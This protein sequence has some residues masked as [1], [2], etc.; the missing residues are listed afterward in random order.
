LGEETGYRYLY[1][2]V[3]E[4]VIGATVDQDYVMLPIEN[5]NV[6]SNDS[7]SPILVKNK[8]IKFKLPETGGGGTGRIYFFGGV[9]TAIGIIS[10]SALYRRKRRRV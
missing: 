9:L 10:L 2:V 3:S 6:A 8:N 5:N 1:Y 4:N 7:S